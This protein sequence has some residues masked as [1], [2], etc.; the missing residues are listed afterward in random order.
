[1]LVSVHSVPQ[2]R[3]SILDPEG[4]TRQHEANRHGDI[5]VAVVRPLRFSY[6][7]DATKTSASWLAAIRASARTCTSATIS[8]A[9]EQDRSRS[10]G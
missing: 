8:P 1:M 3:V 10:R 7:A 6:L 5:V 9:R 4:W 2:L